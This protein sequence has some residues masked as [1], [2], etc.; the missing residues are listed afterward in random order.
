M[1]TIEALNVKS[2]IEELIKNCKTNITVYTD[3]SSAKSITSRRGVT[4]KT[5]HIELRQLFVQELVANGTLQVTKVGTLSNPADIF[6]KFVSSETIQRQLHA[7]GLRST[8]FIHAIHAIRC[9]RSDLVEV[10]ETKAHETRAMAIRNFDI[11][12]F[13]EAE[14]PKTYDEWDEVWPDPPEITEAEVGVMLDDIDLDFDQ[15]QTDYICEMN[16]K[17]HWP[18]FNDAILPTQIAYRA[19]TNLSYANG[20]AKNGCP[21]CARL[22]TDDYKTYRDVQE[23]PND[24]LTDVIRLVSEPYW[25]W[26]SQ[27]IDDNANPDDSRS[28]KKTDD[29]KKNKDEQEPKVPFELTAIPDRREGVLNDSADSVIASIYS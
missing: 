1:A 4:R 15:R 16:T 10:C 28:T 19:M 29:S 7:V 18:I 21:I 26:R 13:P 9:I 8:K 23:M 20:R 27:V 6:T 22:L 14:W 2:T 17:L 11:T 12:K 5:K 24:D 25:P 3:S